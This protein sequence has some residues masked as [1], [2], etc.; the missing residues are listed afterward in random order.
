MGQATNGRAV[1]RARSEKRPATV[2]WLLATI[3]ALSAVLSAGAVHQAARPG[4][5]KIT[6]Q[7]RP[8]SST[9]L[10]ATLSG[11]VID[12]NKSPV[13]DA[14]V[15]LTGP[16]GSI[17]TATD[18]A[19]KFVVAHIAAGTWQVTIQKEGYFELQ[20][21]PVKLAPGLNNAAYTLAHEQEL[22]QNVQVVSAPTVVQPDVTSHR[23]EI[24]QH[25]ILNL[26]LTTSHDLRTALPF[27]PGVVLDPQN[28]IHVAG[29]REEQT[30]F[31]L[32]G[33]EIGD[34]VSGTFSSDLNIDAIRSVDI[35]SGRF[36]AEYAHASAGVMAIETQSGDDRFRFGTTNFTPSPLLQKGIHFGN[37]FPRFTVSGPIL[38]GRAWFADALTLNHTLAI[39]NELPPGQDTS[40][41]WSGSNLLN[42]QVNLTPHQS[43]QSTFLVNLTRI[44]NLGLTALNPA[45]TT[46]NLTGRRYFVSAKDQIVF[47]GSL[48][49]IGG[50]GESD[51]YDD[52]PQGA[53]P[54][55][56]TPTITRG[57]Y[58]ATTT[59]QS[60]RW[61]FIGNLFTPLTESN[62]LRLGFN[63]DWISYRQDTLRNP[64]TVENPGPNGALQVVQQT[65]FFGSPSFRVSNMQ[66]GGYLQDEW[67]LGR[68]F[69]I[70]PGMRLDWDRWTDAPLPA[71]RIFGNFLPFGDKAKLSV[72]Y[73][74]Y[75][76]PTDL[77]QLGMAYDQRR[78]DTVFNPD[79]SVLFGPVTSR[80][81]LPPSGLHEPR[82]YSTSAGW[83]QEIGSR[84]TVKFD[85]M[86]RIGRDELAYDNLRPPPGGDFLL[87]NNRSDRYVG[88]QYS[89]R[90]AISDVTEIFVSYVHSHDTTNQELD[91]SLDSILF[92]PQA[93]GP[94]SWDVPNRWISYGWTP[95]PS[96]MNR[97]PILNRTLLSY[98][99]DYHTGF[100]FDAINREHELAAPPGT[101]RFPNFASLNLAIEKQFRFRNRLWAVRLAAINATDH[102]NPMSV[103]NNTSTPAFM[104]FTG[105]EKRAF[106]A[107]LRL[108]TKSK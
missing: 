89:I 9:P 55:V 8:P 99:L 43:L 51:T 100:P 105:N 88:E 74:I 44:S 94:L 30:E 26:P 4:L 79:G 96:L 24:V 25:Q 35:E 38:K 22:H 104:T 81:L 28:G 73:G 102:F 18:A 61:Q 46:T 6:T 47:G 53:A 66:A 14:R 98:S 78:V 36:G 62:N 65:Y 82:F 32:D 34:P 5:A 56:I 50:A 64:F 58:F 37:W 7:A 101:Y 91:Y 2:A 84:T 95:A 20:N 59:E 85:F 75:Y 49:E 45:S 12:E 90:R 86:Q 60:G 13:A 107:R 71:P 41:S 69:W 57:N 70:E 77:A 103:V 10:Q 87:Q 80:F 106:T 67:H 42:T 1:A 33:F 108:V 63:T 23:E 3:S 68:R 17:V 15:K 97:V 39:V 29:S 76:Q 48:F 92:S 83:T 11:A 54:Y 16:G 93:P 19:G 72:G 31:L 40:N 27:I 52:L 21:V